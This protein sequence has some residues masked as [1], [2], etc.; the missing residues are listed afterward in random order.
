M[1]VLFICLTGCGD[2][3]S[4]VT[5]NTNDNK[6]SDVTTNTNDNVDS[7]Y[8]LFDNVQSIKV[9]VNGLDNSNYPYSLTINDDSLDDFIDDVRVIENSSK[10]ELN[11]DKF[12][13]DDRLFNG[14]SSSPEDED[15]LG[16]TCVTLVIKYKDN[17]SNAKVYEFTDGYED[18]FKD[19]D[20]IRIKYNNE[21]SFYLNE[22]NIIINKVKDMVKDTLYYV[23]VYDADGN[24][25]YTEFL[26]PYNVKTDEYTIEGSYVNRTFLMPYLED[27]ISNNDFVL[28]E[29]GEKIDKLPDDD[30]EHDIYIEDENGNLFQ[31]GYDR[32]DPMKCIKE[33][34]KYYCS[35]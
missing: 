11:S 25:L 16:I 35:Y 18:I 5:T 15:N 1:L 8:G 19:G 28:Y 34:N 14:I 31:Y 30:L 27:Y 4:D 9:I 23:Q 26:N 24:Y 13:E 22:D 12:D 6:D 20:G 3:G 21:I 29:D 33:D 7:E 2:K 32:R 17:R 10:Q